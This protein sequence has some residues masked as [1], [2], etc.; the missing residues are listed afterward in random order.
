MRGSYAGSGGVKGKACT[1]GVFWAVFLL[2]NSVDMGFFK[3]GRPLLPF[4]VSAAGAGGAAG[5]VANLVPVG[6]LPA[7][8]PEDCWRSVGVANEDEVLA[9][10]VIARARRKEKPVLIG[11]AGVSR[12]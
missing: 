4:C 12:A 1:S 6:R 3:N 2:I 5:S 8:A 11:G 7:A 9:C 10:L